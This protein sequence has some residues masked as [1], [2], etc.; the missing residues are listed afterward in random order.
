MQENPE[1]KHIIESSVKIAQN[2]GHE[3]VT[4]EHLLLSLVRHAPF[5]KCLDAFGVEVDQMDTEIEHYL[6]SQLNLISDSIDT[7]PRRT[8]ALERIFNRANVQVMF[9]GRRAIATIDMYLSIMA[10]TNSH[11]HYFLLKYGVKKQEFVEFWQKNYKLVA[12]ESGMSTGQADEILG[13]Y[14][15]NLS[16]MAQENRLEPLIGRATELEEMITVLARRFKAN[17]LMVGDPGVGK[18]AIIDGLAQEIH[19]G[20]VPE[21]IKGYEVWGLEIGSLLAGSKYRGEFEEKFKAVITA[22]EAKKNCILFID[23]AHT[24]KGAG[25]GSGSSLDFANR[26]TGCVDH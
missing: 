21:F 3:Y 22:L 24:M 18:T 9:T 20:T 8:V 12:S 13:E 6:V 2:F 14:C 16:K 7:Q 4:T 25:A 23:E 5:K 1:I 19:K 11:A 26:R 15:I 17:V 10:E